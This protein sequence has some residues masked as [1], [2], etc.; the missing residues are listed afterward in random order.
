MLKL[1]YLSIVKIITRYHKL[2][3]IHQ[4]TTMLFDQRSVMR[5]LIFSTITTGT[6]VFTFYCKKLN[7][8]NRIRLSPSKF[9]KNGL[10]IKHPQKTKDEEWE[11]N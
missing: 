11:H 3:K 2:K 6:L 10:R 9:N 4:M 5:C 8:R 1:R 7:L